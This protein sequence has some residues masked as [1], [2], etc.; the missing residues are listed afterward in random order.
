M[1]KVVV[2]DIDGV[3]TD[4]MVWLNDRGEEFKG[5]HYRDLDALT[6]LAQTGFV[7]GFITGEDRP[8]VEVF[9]QRLPHQ[10]FY[11]GRKDKLPVVQEIIRHAGVT[12]RELCY[13]G[14]GYRD[15]P[16]M[17]YAGVGV[18]PCNAAP[19]VR[20]RADYVLSEP[21]GYGAIAELARLL[22]AHQ[23]DTISKVVDEEG[24]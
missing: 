6:E 8:I 14:D 22:R 23:F 20:E 2:L 19:E 11:Q 17:R 24:S 10:Y 5:L 4:G 7:L 21:G 18:C 1:I 15:I 13:V 3:L 12:S 9:R 16:A